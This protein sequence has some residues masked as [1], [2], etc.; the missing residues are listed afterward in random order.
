MY[1]PYTPGKGTQG[2]TIQGKGQGKGTTIQGTIQGKNVTHISQAEPYYRFDPNRAQKIPE[3]DPAI[4]QQLYARDTQ[5]NRSTGYSDA[6]YMA[7]SQLSQLYFSQ[8]NETIIQNGL[9]AG[10]YKQSLLPTHRGPPFILSAQN[11][12]MVKSVMLHIYG[13]HYT[14]RV[15]LNATITDQIST[16]N[17]LVLDWIVPRLYSD[18]CNHWHHITHIDAPIQVQDMPMPTQYDRDWKSIEYSNLL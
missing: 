6:P 18:A 10:V 15:P 7:D 12:E 4:Q 17:Q 8:E 1:S 2:I 16:L 9:R 11:A 14:D 3:P 13:M 5:R